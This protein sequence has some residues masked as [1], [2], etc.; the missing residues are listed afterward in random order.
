MIVILTQCFPSRIGG[1]ENLMFNL[2]YNL[3]KKCKVI[4]L[5]D[6]HNIIKDTIF[7]NKFKKD[8]LVRRFG[9]IKYFRKR[10]KIRELEK[11]ISFK[12]VNAIICDSWKS[13]EVPIQKFK[14]KNLPFICLV[15]GNEVIIKN[16]RH[17]KRILNCFNNVKKIIPNSEY[18]KNLIKVINPQLKNIKIINPGV[19]N[20][21]N[22]I[23][24]D[25]RLI[26]GHPTLLTLARLEK[27]KG[28]KYILHSINNLKKIHP[29]IRYIIA[30]EGEERSNLE[31]LV[32]SLNIAKNVMFIGSINEGQKKFILKN[33]NL[34]V[35]PTIDESEK[36]SIEGFGISYIEAAMFGIPSIASNVGGTKEAVLHNETGM[37]IDNLD[38]LEATISNLLSNEIKMKDLGK[39]AKLR[40]EVKL[41][42]S[43]IIKD[44]NNLIEEINL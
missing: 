16:K 38:K 40:A 12:K 36:Q 13:L 15:H 11:I 27:R 18:T 19:A 8:F 28:H 32:S 7:D 33:T 6:Q 31:D 3:S 22:I 17:H 1:I 39:K 14:N 4:V 10:N 37:I 29:N 34:M 9:G 5:A 43:E 23:E 2:T 30:G 25:V 44:Y 24:Q 35:M 42:W 26:N 21:D 20:F 41:S